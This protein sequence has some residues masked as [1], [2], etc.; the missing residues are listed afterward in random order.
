MVKSVAALK[1][2][3]EFQSFEFDL[4]SLGVDE[5]DIAVEYCGVC[6]SD[7]SM[8]QNEWNISEYPLVPGHEIV[9]T[10]KEIGPN[11]SNFTVG[12]RVGLGWFSGSC[13]SCYQCVSGFQNLCPDTEKTVVNRHGGF[14][15]TV[16]A[17]SAWVK[18]I[19]ESL[20]PSK[21]GPLFCG[22]LTVFNPIIQNNVQPTDKVGVIGIGGLGHLALQFL[23]KW[24]CEVTAF[25]TSES[26]IDAAKQMG[27]HNVVINTK[28]SNLEKEAGKY[29]FILNTVNVNLDWDMY[30]AAL[31][32]RGRFHTVG[33]IVDP[34]SISAGALIQQQKSIKGSPLGGLGVLDNM[35][36]FCNR[37]DIEAIT[38][39][40][41]MSQVNEAMEHLRENKARYRIVLKNDL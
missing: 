25:T 20:D 39:T 17:H 26:K 6:H 40:Y 33:V 22:G 34:L 12:Q 31:G 2:G 16:R 1:P 18:P 3:A 11:V 13:M 24:G 10:I 38:E 29:D 30:I 35:L 37:H 41:N 28:P 15:D 21:A 8:W 4:P 14:A 36:E 9:G 5:V 27:A 19:P 23:N 7:Y 32:P